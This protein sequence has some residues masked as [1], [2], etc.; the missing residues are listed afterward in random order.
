MNWNRA[1]LKARAKGDL[2]GSYWYAF[3]VSLLVAITGGSHHWGGGGSDE[4]SLWMGLFIIFAVIIALAIRVFIGFAIEVGGR[5]FFLQLPEGNNDL[6]YIGYGFQRTRYY[7]IVVTMLLRGIYLILWT[8]LLI[9]PGIIKMYAYRMVPY[10]L[11]DNPNIG[12]SRAI[13]LSSQMTMGEKFDIF[14]LDLSFLGWFL[15]GALA[16]GIGVLFV[17][18]YYDATNAELY[19]KLREKALD[20][21][22][23]TPEELNGFR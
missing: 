11:A 17:Q 15:L 22:I 12:H 5:K 19:F 9:I 18:P 1:E 20:R 14:V 2:S 16:L 10:I 7:D 4:F 8:L 3:L 13:D 23:T 21:G 6:G